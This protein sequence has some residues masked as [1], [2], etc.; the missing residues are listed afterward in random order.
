MVELARVLFLQTNFDLVPELNSLHGAF[1]VN[2]Q[3]PFRN[4]DGA[5]PSGTTLARALAR[6]KVV[7]CVGDATSE[8]DMAAAIDAALQG[9]VAY[10][11]TLVHGGSGSLAVAFKRVV[12]RLLV[13]VSYMRSSVA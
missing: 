6:N 2:L 10:Q 3:A 13:R 4:S 1:P 9:H 12:D 11:G 5:L 7:M 8:A